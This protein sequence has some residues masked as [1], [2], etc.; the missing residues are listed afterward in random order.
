LLLNGLIISSLLEL[1]AD[2]ALP[3]IRRAF[4]E[5]RVDTMVVDFDSVQEEFDLPGA[6]PPRTY[7]DPLRK[8]DGLNLRLKCTACG[9]ERPHFIKKI[10][11]D[12]GA[13]D[14]H[15]A[16]TESQYSEFVIPQR[17]ICPKC[18]A[19]DQYELGGNAMLTLMAELLAEVARHETGVK[20]TNEDGPLAV[21]RFTLT[22]GREMHP[23]AARDMYRLQVEADPECVDLRLCYGNVLSF[24]GYQD[25]AVAQYRAAL[26]RDPANIEVLYSLATVLHEQGNLDG[27]RRHLEQVLALAPRS[28]LPRAQRDQFVESARDLLHDLSGSFVRVPD[29]GPFNA[30]GAALP[31]G[32]G[33]LATAK[34]APLRVEKVGRNDPCPGGS[35]L[36]YKKC[37]GR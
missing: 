11:Y 23:Y 16:G 28:P 26:E 8:K 29:L 36:K 17:I 2:A 19:V 27:S 37:H 34:Q 24:L 5:D 1:K 14:R 3:A 15:K 10:Y 35:G 9:F 12:R 18:G 30:R 25:E 6:P 20:N 21:Q 31:T 33:A 7:Q 13:A 4:D 32:S 22:D